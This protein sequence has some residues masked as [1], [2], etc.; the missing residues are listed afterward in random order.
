MIIADPYDAATFRL[1]PS[2]RRDAEIVFVGRLVFEKGGHVLLEALALLNSRGRRY[3]LTVVGRGPEEEPLRRLA[4]ELDLTAQVSFL[5]VQTGVEL[6]NILNA[7]RILVV[8]SLWEEPFGVVALE[9]CA[10]GCVVLGTDRGGLPEAIGPCG[11]T[12]PKGDPQ[13]LADHIDQFFSKPALLAYYRA[14]S[15]AHLAK[16]TPRAA[17]IAYLR[18]FESTLAK[19]KHPT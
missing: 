2:V 7:H 19:A 6:A 3:R 17:A 15:Q 12:I 16:H 8:P 10:C 1:I 9:G 14:G 13:S 5:G 11:L 18:V 4:R